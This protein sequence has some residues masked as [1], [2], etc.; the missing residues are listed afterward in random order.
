MVQGNDSRAGPALGLDRPRGLGREG[1]KLL[2]LPAGFG[3]S[4]AD[5][6][7]HRADVVI[8]FGRVLFADLSDFLD[9][10]VFAHFRVRT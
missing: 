5:V 9:N 10:Q 4:L 1:H 8:E 2:T 7:D 6:F 3:F